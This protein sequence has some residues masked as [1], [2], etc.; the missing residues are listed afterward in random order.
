LIG[1]RV[2]L[3]DGKLARSGGRVV[4][5]VSGYDL[6]K[7]HLGAL[8]SLGVIVEAAFKVFPRPLHEA[9]VVTETQGAAAAWEQAQ[10][11]LNLPLPPVAL[12]ASGQGRAWSLLARFE[13]TREA[14]ER[15]T[16]ELAWTEAAPE[17]WEVLS[18]RSAP[19]WARLAVPP[20]ALQNLLVELDGEELIAEPGV[21]ILHWFGA[22]PADRLAEVRGLTEAQGG[23]LVLLAAPAKLKQAVG[24]W[25]RPPA[26]LDLMRSLKAAFD[27]ADVLSA[28]RYVF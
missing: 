15:M 27:P 23:S 25:G 20:A 5:N 9:T 1:L 3:P 13:G 4:K 19:S 12:E 11:A 26:T 7:L 24:A 18:K 21:G 17:A 6:N 16:R 8:G 28:G 14:V 22:G 2:A 10:R